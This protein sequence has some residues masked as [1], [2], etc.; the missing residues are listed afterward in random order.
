MPPNYIGPLGF[1]KKRNQPQRP[2]LRWQ[3]RGVRTKR[4]PLTR[5]IFRGS[6]SV[7]IYD[8]TIN[9]N[10]H[11]QEYLILGLLM[12]KE[13]HGYDLHHHLSSTMGQAWYAGKSQ[14]YALLKRLEATGY[15][16]SRT[17]RQEPKPPR[18]VYAI[19]PQGKTAFNH[20]VATPVQRIRDLRLEFLTKLFFIRHLG[21]SDAE[22]LL[23]AQADVCRKRL[24]DVKLQLVRIDDPFARLVYDFRRC[25]IGAVIDW[26]HRARSHIISGSH[27]PAQ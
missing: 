22:H 26:L 1:V 8:M 6:H 12:M 17:E 7:T 13:R 24:E 23:S 2:C 16:V 15:I 25:Q 14:I 9:L 18:K 4:W 19:T 20:W 10:R 11:P 27:P 21:L 3:R 5:G